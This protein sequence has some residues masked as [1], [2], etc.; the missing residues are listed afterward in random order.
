M[1]A[2]NLQNVRPD[3]REAAVLQQRRWLK[4]RRPGA[5]TPFR[6]IQPL[7][8][9]VW[10]VTGV[11]ALFSTSTF[12]P[13]LTLASVLMVP[14]IASLLLFKGDSPILFACCMMQWLQATTAIFY[15]DFSNVSLVEAFEYPNLELAT[16]LSLGGVFAVALGMRLGLGKWQGK[17][18]GMEA[19]A[20]RIILPRLTILWVIAFFIAS[21]A[22]R[23]AWG[24]GGLA[25]VI[26][27]F[28][29]IKWVVFF[30]LAYQVATVGKGTKTLVLLLLI[31]I[32][33]GF[34]GFFSGFKD[35]LIMLLVA[36]ISSGR[37]LSLKTR[38]LSLLVFIFGL[39][40]S[41]VW[42]AVK[43]DFRNYLVES[44][45]YGATSLD[46]IERLLT[47]I[48]RVSREEGLFD[49]GFKKLVERVSYIQLFGQSLEYVPARVP[50]A[51]GAL[52]LGAIQHV[53]TPRILFPNKAILDDS[54]RAVKYTGLNLAGASEGTSIG[55]GYMAESYVDFGRY[56]MH[57]PLFLFGFFV[58]RIYRLFASNR[59]SPLWGV[60]TGTAI[61]FSILQAYATSNVK[62]FGGLCMVT[63]VLWTLDRYFGVRI[64]AWLSNTSA[65]A[66]RI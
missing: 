56:G 11:L 21:I 36:V 28:T 41:I 52:W 39:F 65:A 1:N 10:L 5:A 43:V 17:P 6:L 51:D 25:Q 9:S 27:A 33:L 54:S 23:L 49:V 12:Y 2:G 16:W 14:F 58:A 19:E 22:G 64:R 4:S 15:C 53:L 50:H 59:L 3:S 37:R 18:K 62:L 46:K 40:A 55:I 61:A 60:A 34:I 44:G 45:G 63:L 31:Q 13:M 8:I 7:P 29:N 20:R 66:R 35:A 38:L 42:S 32:V 24:L 47:T 26:E 57:V 48:S 30:V